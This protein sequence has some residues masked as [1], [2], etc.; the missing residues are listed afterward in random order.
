M[1]IRL[2]EIVAHH[3]ATGH[4]HRWHLATAPGY[5]SRSD[6][7]PAS[8][9]WLPLV[10][11]WASVAVQASGGGGQGIAVDDLRL[12]NVR[13]ADALP[14]WANVFDL[15]DGVWLRVSLGLRPLNP[16]VT[17]YVVQAIVEREVEEGA[18]YS[19]AVV[20]WRAK[21]GILAPDRTELRLPV[22]D[23]Q[24]D[25]DAPV[26]TGTYAGTGGTEGPAELANV[27][28][29]RCFGWHAVVIPTYLGV[30][31]VTGK[32]MYSVNGGHPIEGV[33]KAWDKAAPY[34]LVVGTPSTT[35]QYSVNTSTGIILVGGA[36]PEDFRCEVKGDKTGGVWRRHIGAVISHL[37]TTAGLAST[38]DVSG[39][40]AIPRTIGVSLPAGDTTTHAD[41]YDRLVGSVPRGRWYTDLTDQLVVTRLLRAVEATPSR[42][43][44]KV[45]GE[46]PGL[47]PMTGT[48]TVPAKQAV[49]RYA[50]NPSPSDQTAASASAGDVALWSKA[51]RE[52]ASEVDAAIVAAWGTSTKVAYIETALTLQADAEAEAPL[53]AAEKGD[54][55]M[56]YELKVRDGA[57][58]L[59]IGGACKVTDDVAGF[60][61]GATVVVTGRTNR[62]RGGGATLYVER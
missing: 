48:R 2:Y 28:K 61:A 52:A 42:S 40:D 30:D 20:T 14:R 58:G 12:I 60:E 19:T 3:R 54:P 15:T 59:W 13:S 26:L 4:L 16:L 29:E 24:G 34:T 46:T 27:T 36:K 44:R 11:Q 32:H 9:T 1:R 47:R 8:V 7:T 18:S 38:V 41:L 53:W 49:V 43:Y 33:P 57:P 35:G 23:R 31:T 17:D 10:G 51:W 6:D 25:F 56:P 62:D 50:G 39:M 22:Y 37:A 55:P 45:A 21:A 5:R